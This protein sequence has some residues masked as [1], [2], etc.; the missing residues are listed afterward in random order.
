MKKENKIQE[1]NDKLIQLEILFQ[2]QNEHVE[3]KGKLSQRN[4]LIK[5]RSRRNVEMVQPRKRKKNRETFREDCR[6]ISRDQTSNV[7]ACQIGK[8]DI[9]RNLDSC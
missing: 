9:T 2:K 1:I 3:T 8:I 5:I 7:P 4:D 6:R